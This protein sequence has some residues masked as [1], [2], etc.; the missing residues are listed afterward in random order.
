MSETSVEVHVDGSSGPVRAG[1]A[2]F[3]RNRGRVTTTFDYDPGYL[4]T[5]DAPSV[6]PA[7]PLTRGAQYVAKLP[8]SF[9]D[10]A[11]DRWG[12]NLIAKRERAI[13]REERRRARDLDDVDYLLG[14]S[15]DT[16]Q[17]AL[18]FRHADG[19]AFLGPHTDVPRLLEL[20]RLL[21]AADEA[22]SDDDGA[23]AVKVLLDA[24]TGS[25]GGA[26]PKAAVRLDDGA[27]GLAKFPHASDEWDV[28]AWEATALDIAGRAGLEVPDHRLTKVGPRHVL[29]LP[30]IRPNGRRDTPGVHECS[31]R[32]RWRRRCGLR[33]SRRRRRVG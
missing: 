23:A 19:S 27:L 14:V 32:P 22:A 26:R 11:P 9:G 21:R 4:R 30:P 24:G 10:G 1:T 2:F 28:M 20:P 8:G 31:D 33:L 3:T 16:R 18:R 7:F 5:A 29:L 12:R 13:A 25:L 17:G 15:D 6:D